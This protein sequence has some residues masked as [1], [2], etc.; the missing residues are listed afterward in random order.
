MEQQ[1]DFA[2]ERERYVNEYQ[3]SQRMLEEMREAEKNQKLEHGEE[4]EKGF[5][6]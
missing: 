6:P 5:S 1:K 4:Q 3:E 2:A